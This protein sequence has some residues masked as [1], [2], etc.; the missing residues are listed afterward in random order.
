[1]S[2]D[3]W[4]VRGSGI[5]KESRSRVSGFG[6]RRGSRYL[7]ATVGF[8]VFIVAMS[9]LPLASADGVS[10]SPSMPCG[11]NCIPGGCGGGG[12]C[13]PPSVAN[14][15]ARVVNGYEAAW[16][17]WNYSGSYSSWSPS[18]SWSGGAIPS[19]YKS[20]NMAWINLNDLTSGTSYSFTV[21]VSDQCSSASASG[22]F[23]TASAPT[24][25]FVGWVSQLVSDPY[26]LDQIGSTVVS[27]ATVAVG[28]NCGA[29]GNPFYFPATTTDNSGYYS[30]A[31]PI[32]YSQQGGEYTWTLS[33][34]GVCNYAIYF[35]GSW[36]TANSH[37]LL[38][39]NK[40]GFWNATQYVSS[41]L[42]A[43]NDFRQFGLDSNTG[44]LVPVGFVLIH[45]TYNGHAYNNANCS[46]SWST[47]TTTSTVT[48]TTVVGLASGTSETATSGTGW[49]TNGG[50]GVDV[51]LSLKY[52]FSGLINETGTNPYVN[53]SD[54]FVVGGEYGASSAPYTSTEWL[55]APTFSPS[56]PP[57][58]G[59]LFANP[60]N[61]APLT[62][63]LFGQGSYSSTSG[64]SAQIDVSGSV[65]GGVSV[66]GTVL[67]FQTST[68]VSTSITNTV[69]CTYTYSTDPSNNGGSPYF[70]T[71]VGSPATAV[72]HVWLAGWCGGTN[73]PAC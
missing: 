38:K 66:G 53:S 11:C 52:P 1:M 28:A 27:G 20:G 39:A 71:Y 22:S 32:S 44:Q 61:G 25:G 47:S 36:N 5:R 33:S 37:Y 2:G 50:G 67:S 29:G 14:Y 17:Y 13:T 26:Q 15:Q 45:T 48:Q 30:F 10:P 41:S 63:D 70:W 65:W 72:D 54:T 51:G 8:I 4:G 16:V 21:T 23:S 49:D 43:Q 19:I 3:D 9:A 31:F 35:V 59:W 68:S 73:E 7:G 6:R 46:L 42:S 18:F 40:N 62:L 69:H 34:S 57:P 24:N 60:Q 55:S 58:S 56:T 12:G 64:F